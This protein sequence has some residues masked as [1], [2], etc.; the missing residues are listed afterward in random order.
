MNPMIMEIM[1]KERIR[2][3]EAEVMGHRPARIRRP[4]PRPSFFNRIAD[5]MFR[6]RKGR[7]MKKRYALDTRP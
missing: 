4:S 1:V 2:D 3:L 6:F 5:G 7:R